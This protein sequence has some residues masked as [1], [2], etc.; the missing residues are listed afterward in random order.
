MKGQI[1]SRCYFM[2]ELLSTLILRLICTFS[3]GKTL[4]FYILP[5]YWNSL[6]APLATA[7]WQFY[8]TWTLDFINGTKPCSLC[9]IFTCFRIHFVS[10]VVSRCSHKLYLNYCEMEWEEHERLMHIVA[11]FVSDLIFRLWYLSY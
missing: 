3:I 11:I 7:I 10:F 1:I 5:V 4:N 6:V 8:A 2:F 9:L